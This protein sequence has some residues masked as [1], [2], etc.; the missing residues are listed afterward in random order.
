MNVVQ[1]LRSQRVRKGF[2][3]GLLVVAVLV[4]VPFL[5]YAFPEL[6]GA[7]ESYVVL[8]G[9]MQPTLAPGDIIIVYEQDPAS[10]EAGDIITYE[11]GTATLVTHRI[12]AVTQTEDE[13]LAFET[14][15]DNN[16]DADAELVKA[17]ALVGKVPT[18]GLPLLG[19][20]PIY[21]PMVGYIVVFINQSPVTF[22]LV[23]GAV[24]AIDELRRFLSSDDSPGN[25]PID[26]R[27]LPDPGL[28]TAVTEPATPREQDSGPG[29]TAS[30]RTV[31]TIEV[32]DRGDASGLVVSGVDLRLTAAVLVVLGLYSG[33]AGLLGRS[34]LALAIAAGA[35]VSVGYIAVTLYDLGHHLLLTRYHGDES[36]TDHV[37]SDLL[38]PFSPPASEP[39]PQ[40]G[41]TP[42]EPGRGRSAVFAGL[43]H[44]TL[45]R[46]RPDGPG[47]DTADSLT[48]GRA[49]APNTDPSEPRSN[50][51]P[52][53]DR[54]DDPPDPDL[55]AAPNPD[56]DPEPTADRSVPDGLSTPSL[57]VGTVDTPTT[58]F[59]AATDTH[60]WVLRGTEE[61]DEKGSILLL[62]ELQGIDL[63]T[64]VDLDAVTGGEAVGKTDGGHPGDSE[65]NGGESDDDT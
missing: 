33:V 22:L 14:K 16:E 51:G 36:G 6:A 12:V 35:F 34:A 7:S 3:I 38:E 2:Q 29:D 63:P 13:A 50:G 18:L 15:G 42:S 43:S 60:T 41:S 61:G 11:R 53:A 25:D 9:S 28:G 4:L 21:F 19:E 32:Q 8:S 52:A 56:A 64:R 55:S 40:P 47:I 5:V 30:A 46:Y 23:I 48:T 31:G 54:S 17:S 37:Q 1:T 20:V 65:S 24:I 10:L 26:D 57:P 59:D 62:S 39:A 49:S 58:L 45:S 44:L 27:D